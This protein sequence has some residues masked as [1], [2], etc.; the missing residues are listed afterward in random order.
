MRKLVRTRDPRRDEPGNDG[1]RDCPGDA[2]HQVV[3][4]GPARFQTAL[5]C[6]QSAD[7]DEKDDE[8]H[9]NGKQ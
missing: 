5:E 2:E 9:A 3:Q 4:D 8:S 1:A 7:N 6:A